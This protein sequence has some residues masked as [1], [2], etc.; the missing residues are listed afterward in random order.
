MMQKRT[1]NTAGFTLLE[2][3]MV[4]ALLGIMA[5]IGVAS[6]S[7]LKSGAAD[8]TAEKQ[9]Y[10]IQAA[11]LHSKSMAET[12]GILSSNTFTLSLPAT[13]ED[14]L[15]AYLTDKLSE[16]LPE[17]EGTYS[18]EAESKD[19]ALTYTITYLANGKAYTLTQDGVVSI[20]G[21]SL[22]DQNFID[23]I[24]AIMREQKVQLDSNA[25]ES[26]DY[27]HTT[28]AVNKMQSE[29]IDI[30]MLGAVSWHCDANAN[31]LYWSTL[32][33]KEMALG[34]KLPTI[35]YN[36]NTK[37]YTVWIAMVKNRQIDNDHPSLYHVLDSFNSYAPSTVND[38]G[39]QT[40]QQAQIRYKEAMK[41]YGYE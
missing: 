33:I 36:P 22:A 7:G 16:Q 8:K 12:G 20:A 31:R 25:V 19:G 32:D 15:G 5:L 18:I 14:I 11:F 9:L 4:L 29:G 37:T 3:C 1:K 24:I 41:L 13:E 17:L 26:Y 10:N 6:Y 40:Y 34:A 35:C 30:S 39:N 2:L 21:G 38:L 23:R 27:C 28:A